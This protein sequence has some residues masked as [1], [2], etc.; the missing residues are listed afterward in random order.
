VSMDCAR[1][2]ARE[3]QRQK[4]GKKKKREGISN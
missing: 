2:S 1:A 3:G 4:H